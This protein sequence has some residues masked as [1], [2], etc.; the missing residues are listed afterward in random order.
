MHPLTK[1]GLAVFAVLAVSPLVAVRFFARRFIYLPTSIPEEMLR[2]FASAEG[3]SL[4]RVSVEPGVEL[5]GLVRTGSS[6]ASRWILFFGGNASDLGGN[7][8]ALE[9][10]EHRAAV[11]D[12]ERVVDD[13]GQ[14]LCL[15]VFVIDD[16]RVPGKLGSQDALLLAGPAVAEHLDQGRPGVSR[17]A[18]WRGVVQ[19]LQRTQ[20]Q[21][22]QAN[23]DIL[24]DNGGSRGFNKRTSS[25]M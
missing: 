12:D 9:A 15:V 3:W 16:D 5:N 11:M 8:A 7:Q 20:G 18:P 19:S 23:Q 4:E 13:R 21:C 14:A 10:I 2:A 25:G 22:H 1:L 17:P 6:A 24:S